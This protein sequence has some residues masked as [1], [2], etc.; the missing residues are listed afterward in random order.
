MAT[1]PLLLGDRYEVGRLLGAGGMAEVFE[2]RDRLLARRVAIKVLLAEFSQDP[3]FVARFKREAQAAASLSHPN[4][5][6]VWD[7]G[8][9]GG[10]N[11]IVMEYVEGR[12][13]RD[14]LRIGGPPPADRAVGIAADVCDALAAAHARGLIHRDV[15]PGNVMLTGDG[16]VKVMDFGIARAT[17]SQ[18]L[19]QTHAVIGTAQYISPEQVE[20]RQVDAR[21]DLYSVGCMLYEMLTG[22]VPFSGESP[23]AIAYRHVRE[24]PVPPRRID[25]RIPPAF[26]AITMRA[27]AKNPDH[28]YQSAAE[29]RAELERALAGRPIAAAAAVG[30][31]GADA[32]QAMPP[33]F[34]HQPTTHLDEPAPAYPGTPANRSRPAVVL[35]GFVAVLLAVGA[36]T[37]VY[38][39]AR[40]Q[41]SPQSALTT[42]P[43]TLAP[44]TTQPAPT[45]TVAQTTT[46]QRQTTTTARQTTTTAAQTTTSLA[47][48]QVLVP[49]VL[50]RR[51]DVAR[52]LLEG[53]GFEVNSQ[54]VQIQDR[55]FDG[56]VVAQ[57]P[58]PNTAA[59]RGS[60]VNIF[61]GQVNN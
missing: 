34:T 20:G 7:T 17:S 27:M 19:T 37:F 55:R 29:M 23:V 47:E 6:G 45:T 1:T 5:V 10:T 31:I 18:T 35:L 14:L 57:S 59:Q 43:T 28:R 53:Q 49:N 3:S 33:A 42:L 40:P 46:T 22:R 44:P 60:T 13:L 30:G 15:K 11:F 48:G 38:K 26:E 61:I 51:E 36:F 12:T 52:Q 50:G 56:R 25:P 41:Q 54:H 24:D 21:S 39:N 32:T 9:E 58:G 2:G 8:V 4:I 16:T